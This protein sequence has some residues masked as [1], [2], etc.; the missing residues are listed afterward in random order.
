MRSFGFSGETRT[1]HLPL[2]HLWQYVVFVAFLLPALGCQPTPE[3]ESQPENETVLHL[4]DNYS[5]PQ[6]SSP[7]KQLAYANSNF[8]DIKEKI[9]AL[10][11][12]KKIFPTDRLH[13]G[14]AELERIYLD[15]GPDYRLA[16]RSQYKNATTAYHNI[17]TEY[18][19][20][21][22]IRAK[23]LWYLGWIS[24]DLLKERKKGIEY[25]QAIAEDDR[26]P[27]L[28]LTSPPPWLS[29]HSS[30]KKVPEQAVFN[31]KNLSWS[32]IANLE[33]IRNSSDQTVQER[34]L[35]LL[36]NNNGTDHVTGLGLKV[37]VDTADINN[38]SREILSKYLADTE[39]KNPVRLDIHTLM[40][41]GSM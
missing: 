7:Q 32:D 6:F 38:R 25:Y 39:M 5:V 22:D 26:S 27:S 33:I 16:N 1:N 23:A 4:I 40:Q 37:I 12:V 30:A 36:Y 21:K 41:Q 17:I 14:L 9:A 8:T 31:Q 3:R 10:T 29:I 2:K 35:A 11:A 18:G 19:D 20:I 15:L 24:C 28:Q 13:I 34:T